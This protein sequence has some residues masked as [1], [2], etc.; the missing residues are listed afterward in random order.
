[1]PLFARSATATKLV[2]FLQV[3]MML[4]RPGLAALSQGEA[5][6]RRL[7][8]RSA[9]S[10]SASAC[11]AAAQEMIVLCKKEAYASPNSSMQ[12]PWWMNILCESAYF[13][14]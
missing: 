1:M 3:Q 12:T 7:L 10:H 2:R 11:V 14:V 4:Y 9:Y 6:A 5:G 8:R 13:Y